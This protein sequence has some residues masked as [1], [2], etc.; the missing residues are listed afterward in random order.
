MARVKTATILASRGKTHGPFAENARVMQALKREARSGVTYEKLSDAH[1]E[2][3][4][5]ILHKV[6]RIVNGDGN[7]DDH[8]VD[9]SGYAELAKI[10]CVRGKKKA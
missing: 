1:K 10:E 5:M 7:F 3:L 8:W 9:I 6:G 4:D 2:A